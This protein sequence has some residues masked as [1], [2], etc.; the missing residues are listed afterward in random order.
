MHTV[1]RPD[2]TVAEVALLL[3]HGNYYQPL[4]SIV[5]RVTEV[6]D[7]YDNILEVFCSKTETWK[8][9]E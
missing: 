7:S 1:Q 8:R 6:I 9:F 5:A 3:L 4:A 2:A